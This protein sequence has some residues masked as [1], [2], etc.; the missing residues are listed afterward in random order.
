MFNTLNSLPAYFKLFLELSK[1]IIASVS[2]F[3]RVSR[4]ALTTVNI[5]ENLRKLLT[6]GIECHLLKTKFVT[7]ILLLQGYAITRYVILYKL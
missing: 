5:F 3:D 6:V 7:F 1:V 2:L 4:L